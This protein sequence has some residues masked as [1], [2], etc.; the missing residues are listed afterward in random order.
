MYFVYKH[1]EITE[2]LSKQTLLI[3]SNNSVVFKMLINEDMIGIK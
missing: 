3:L 1:I 2:K